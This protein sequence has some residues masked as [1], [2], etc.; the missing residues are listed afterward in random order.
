VCLA[1]DST[2]TNRAVLPGLF[3]V[4]LH[5]LR[6]VSSAVGTFITVSRVSS[7]L[8]SLTL[9]PEKATCLAGLGEHLLP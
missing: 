2:S 5:V 3:Q 9:Q 7:L 6:A 1:Y 4:L 8:S